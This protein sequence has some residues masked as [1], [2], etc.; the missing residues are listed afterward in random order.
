M[1]TILIV[2]DEHLN[3]ELIKLHLARAEYEILTAGDGVEAWQVVSKRYDK[4]DLILLDRNM[5]NMD[6]IAFMHKIK[7][8]PNAAHIP[9]IMQTAASDPERISEGVQAGVY[10]YLTS[11]SKNRSCCH[12]SMPR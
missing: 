12:W 8:D 6:G 2:D 10:Y 4:I 3:I 7:S 11:C 5:P 9:V 1:T